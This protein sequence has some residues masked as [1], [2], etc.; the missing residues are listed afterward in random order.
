M[1]KFKF[2]LREYRTTSFEKRVEVEA[3]NPVEALAQANELVVSFTPSTPG[4]Y[5]DVDVDTDQ[6]WTVM[7]D[8]GDET[9]YD[10]PL[11]DSFNGPT[12]AGAEFL[13]R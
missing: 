5:E 4:S 13:G 12:E 9:D 8:L 11:T 7:E 1:A 2:V 6:D 10:R 3:A